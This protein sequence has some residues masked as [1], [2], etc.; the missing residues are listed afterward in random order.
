MG[1]GWIEWVVIGSRIL[2]VDGNEIGR[3]VIRTGIIFV[4]GMGCGMH[5][6]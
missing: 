5:D 1:D 3:S 4:S 2:W 6:F